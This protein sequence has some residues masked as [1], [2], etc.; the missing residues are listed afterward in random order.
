MANI[1]GTGSS[2]FLLGDRDPLLPNDVL[3]SGWLA[4]D[5]TMA[6]V[7]GDDTY[8]VNSIGDVVFEDD[9]PSSGVDTVVSQIFSYT[10]TDN[11]EKLVLQEQDRS[12]I[13]N[14]NG[15]V[16]LAFSLGAPTAVVGTGNAL[17]NTITGNSNDNYLYGL[18]GADTL[19]GN[20]GADWLFGGEGNDS[21]EGGDDDDSLWGDDG[22]DTMLGGDGEDTFFGNEGND[23]MTGGAGDDTY[24]V[25]DVGDVVVEASAIVSVQPPGIDTVYAS[26]SETLDSNVE[27]LTLTGIGNLN[28]TGNGSANLIKGNVGANV[29]DGKAGA[30]TMEG[31]TGNDTYYVD[32]AGDVVTENA[33]SGT[34]L[35]Y[36]TVTH[37]LRVNV[38]KLTLNGTAAINGTGNTLN[39]TI[40]GNSADNLLKGMNGNDTLI[41]KG[42]DDTVQGGNG[43]DR[44]YGSLGN[45][46]LRAVDD[47]PGVDDGVEDR[48]YF[49]TD[50]AAVDNWDKIEVAT[51]N[52]ADGVDDEL[53]LDD[54]FFVGL[55]VT[56]GTLDQYAEGVDV[57]GNNENDGI[58]V[59]LDTSSGD[60]F[61]NPT[62]NV[63]GDSILFASISNF[64]TGGSASLSASDFTL[65]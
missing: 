59:Y 40:N 27:N 22:N 1:I 64:I 53:Y 55:S 26:I 37:T 61:Y 43:A 28:G 25:D 50:P 24:W 4:G 14:A 3:N 38:E 19:L 18:D 30:D 12:G 13:L 29:L 44:L 47:V 21:M 52:T 57:D 60:L 58:G 2:N 63:A 41:G 11:V 33:A 45:D 16:T 49:S 31:S 48:F 46:T 9:A 20:D 8:N 34:D 62:D 15:T 10:L 32:N 51:F 23:S 39:N 5:D 65:Y 56:G 17:D 36:S 54:A 42:G 6:G 7:N 35:V